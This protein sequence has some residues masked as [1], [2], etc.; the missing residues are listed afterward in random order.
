MFRFR[1]LVAL[2]PA[3]LQQN[4]QI[5]AL[6]Y[7]QCILFHLLIHLQVGTFVQVVKCLQYFSDNLDHRFPD[8]HYPNMPGGFMP[9]N[10]VSIF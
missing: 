5:Q 7:V 6:G 8:F 10:Y 1:S 3:I 9:R 4:I 2:D